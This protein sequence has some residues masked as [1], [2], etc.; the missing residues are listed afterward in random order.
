MLY[1]LNS[2]TDVFWGGVL[3]NILYVCGSA[4]GVSILNQV[5]E[6]RLWKYSQ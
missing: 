3:S 1:K 2:L 6:V 5:Q 4:I